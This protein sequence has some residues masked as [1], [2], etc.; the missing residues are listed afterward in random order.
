MSGLI[1][2]QLEKRFHISQTPPGYVDKWFAGIETKAGVAVDETSALQYVTV[3][4]CI[5]ILAS[6]IGSLPCITYERLKDGGKQRSVDF[7]L[8]PILHDQSN[9]DMTS[10]QLF[11][12]VMGHVA[13]WGNGYIQI[14]FNQ[15]GRVME[16]WPLRPDYMTV[17]RKNGQLEYTYKLDKPDKFGNMERTFPAY[18]ILHIPG[19]GFD[20][21]TGYSPIAMSRQAIGLGLAA[22][23]FGARFFG[24]DARPGYAIEH[25]L[26]LSAPAYDRLKKDLKEEHGGLTKSHTPMILEEGMKLHEIGIPPEDAQFLQTRLFQKRELCGMYRIPPHMAGDL[27][28]TTYNNLEQENLSFAIHTMRRWLVR[29]EQC[30]KAKLLTPAERKRYFSEFLLDGLLRGDLNTRYASY[31]IAKMDGWMNGDEIR[32]LENMNPMPNDQGKIYLF[33]LNMTPAGTVRSQK[34]GKIVVA[35]AAMTMRGLYRD[36]FERIYRREKNDI[37]QAAKK[38]LEKRNFEKF[39]SWMSEFYTEHNE[40]IIRQ[41]KPLVESHSAAISGEKDG[42]GDQISQYLV[43]LGEKIIQN[44]RSKVENLVKKSQNETDFEVISAMEELF[45]SQIDILAGQMAD[46]ESINFGEMFIKEGGR[47]AIS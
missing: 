7:Y 47:D 6:T 45:K 16:L 31:H 17:E 34:A 39:V 36:T 46:I 29:W 21:I 20:G 38:Y 19:L 1:A 23:E 3:F 18:E 15:A 4:T 28:K 32:E 8:Y 14:V 25:P 5:D 44:S 40:F 35:T 11:E 13:S 27:E 22:E 24:N 42:F 41:M 26:S 9:V 10:S 12:T 37:L 43:V 2:S 30:M 33:P